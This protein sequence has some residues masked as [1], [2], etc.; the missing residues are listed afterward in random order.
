MEKIAAVFGATGLTG[1]S[2]LNQL[3]DNKNYAK[4]LVFN[5]N[6]QNYNHDKIDELELDWNNIERII[7]QL[8]ADDLFCCVGITIK[9]AGSKE[10]FKQVDLQIP[11]TL[12]QIAE[13]NKIK[14]LLVV[15]SLGANSKSRNFYLQTKGKMEEE[16]LKFNIPKIHFFRPSMLLGKRNEYRAGEEI[17]KIAMKIFNPLMISGLRKYKAIPA[18]TVAKAMIKIANID[19]PKVIFNSDELWNLV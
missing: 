10:A 11:L 2:L 4:I 13:N 1:K 12:A 19:S 17:G 14:K 3:I 9:K 15:S 5:R 7:N 18:A 6:L 8:I 16:V